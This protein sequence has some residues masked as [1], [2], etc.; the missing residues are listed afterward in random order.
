M[1][2]RFAVHEVWID[3]DAVD[4]P[5]TRHIVE[6]VRPGRVLVGRQADHVKA[7]LDL[8]A[9]PFRK[10]KRVL[11]LVRRRGAWMKPCP[12]TREYICCGLNILHIGQG[13]PMDCRYCAL[14]AYFN[15]PV[16]EVFVNTGELIDA[17]Q[18][19]LE[20]HSDRVRR[21]CTGEFTDSLALDPITEL[22]S[23]LVPLF[24]P[25]SHATLEIKTKT[26][27]VDPLIG[28]D[29]GGRVIVSFSMNA[30]T[31]AAQEERGAVSLSRR[32]NAARRAQEDGYRV[33]FH[34]DPIIPIPSWEEEYGLTI[35]DIFRI[36]NP[37][38]IA[39]I[40]LGVIRFV[41]DLKETV[42][43]RFGPVSYFC[44]SFVR[45]LDGKS[46]LPA[47]RRVEIYA[48]LA[49]RIRTHWAD[50]ALYLCMESPEVWEQ[51]LGVRMDSSRNLA[52]Y[53]DA[54]VLSFSR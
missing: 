31:I 38:G 36:I 2:S 51:S 13:C 54:R 14:Q 49:G 29:H 34:F 41:P 28:L 48:T 7:E 44:D 50:A 18:K 25:R 8:A 1:H 10:G 11:R 5:L 46:R 32:L 19:D 12:G 3:A 43:A 42:R 30:P 40:S 20:H 17:L 23:Q 47:P 6:R 26:D 15:R 35:D 21:I 24:G 33:G 39:W 52:A 27:F 9:D 4:Y 16:I 37:S 45:G 53:L 22:N